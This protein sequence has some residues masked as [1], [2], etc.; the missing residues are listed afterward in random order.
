MDEN[1]PEKT[2]DAGLSHPNGKRELEVAGGEIYLPSIETVK[3][4]EKK[5]EETVAEVLPEVAPSLTDGALGRSRGYSVAAVLLILVFLGGVFAAWH[6]LRPLPVELTG[7]AVG[8]ARPEPR[9]YDGRFGKEFRKAQEQIGKDQLSAARET[10]EPVVDTLL[11][12]GGTE[13]QDANIFYAYFSLFDRLNWDDAARKRL[14]KLIAVSPDEYRWKFFHIL[15]HPALARRD[16]GFGDP[17][18]RKLE[19]GPQG[20]LERLREIDSLRRRHSDAELK[21]QL[22]LCECYLR[23]NLWR[24]K[25]HEKRSAAVGAE[26]REKALEIAKKYDHDRDFLK[27]RRRIVVQMQRD[28]EGKFIGRYRFDGRIFYTKAP[29]EIE[30]R[31]LKKKLDRK[32][33]GSEEK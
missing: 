28:S 22:D 24:L 31:K 19:F 33:N 1:L 30:R 5:F 8:V 9:T 20:I 23:M 6:L 10:L 2:P 16:G 25:N 26:E 14:A 11:N 17:N 32:N 13:A 27:V 4:G 21:R 12:E 18:D 15:S 29:L 3:P 7:T